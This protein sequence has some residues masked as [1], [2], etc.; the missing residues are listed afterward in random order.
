VGRKISSLAAL[1]ILLA[2]CATAASSVRHP[3]HPA[4]AV[5]HR[6]S[7]PASTSCSVTLANWSQPA[8]GRQWY[9]AVVADARLLLADVH[10]AAIADS[11]IRADAGQLET[12]ARTAQ[13]NPPPSC[14][15]GTREYLNAM[16]AIALAGRDLAIGE[17]AAGGRAFG[18][19]FR[20]LARAM[21]AVNEA[22]E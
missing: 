1:A 18:A 14:S 16:G 10:D 4:V 21:A 12:D 5:S 6:A 7:P 15:G 3:E 9:N 19:G 13:S 17:L 8:G 22:L 2:G 20:L 11:T